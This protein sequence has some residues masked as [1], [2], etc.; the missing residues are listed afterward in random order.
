MQF[1]VMQ[2]FS[3]VNEIIIKKQKKTEKF[4]IA[5]MHEYDGITRAIYFLV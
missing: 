2:W 4:K 1:G 3:T 5:F